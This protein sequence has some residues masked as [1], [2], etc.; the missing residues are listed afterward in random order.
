[1]YVTACIGINVGTDRFELAQQILILSHKSIDEELHKA[2]SL[3]ILGCI[4]VIDQGKIQWEGIYCEG[5]A[6]MQHSGVRTN[7]IA[8]PQHYISV[9]AGSAASRRDTL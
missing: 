7:G 1:M 6:Y 9:T 4:R 8:C 2:I 3:S 5:R